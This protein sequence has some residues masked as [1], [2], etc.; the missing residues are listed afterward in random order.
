M[1]Q[2]YIIQKIDQNKE[3][4][5]KE[6]AEL[7]KEVFSL[8][9]H[10]TYPG[11]VI[12]AAISRGKEALTATLRTQNMYPIGIYATQIA[13]AVIELFDSKDQ[14]ADIRELIFDDIE[15]LRKEQIRKPDLEDI[16]D[17]SVEIDELL[18]DDDADADF[19]DNDIEN[20][21]YPI[22]IADDDSVNTDDDD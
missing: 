21:T 16:D 19:D 4:V 10:E 9:C 5:I 2:K 18:D 8:L 17:D 1:K 3:L 13:Q 22:K 7:D 12:E 11:E 6:F 20:I 15:L 14:A